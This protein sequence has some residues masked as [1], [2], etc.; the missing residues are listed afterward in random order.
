L[1]SIKTKTFLDILVFIKCCGKT[2][3]HNVRCFN[4]SITLPK[5]NTDIKVQCSLLKVT[6]S[7]F[8][9]VQC[10]LGLLLREKNINAMSK[11]I[12]KLRNY[13]LKYAI[14]LILQLGVS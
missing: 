6:H 5:N 14:S 13:R 2:H 4:T 12:D 1:Y 9:H 10:L 7:F 3:Y 11:N 8:N